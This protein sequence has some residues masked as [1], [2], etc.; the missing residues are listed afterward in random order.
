MTKVTLKAFLYPPVATWTG[1]IS[2]PAGADSTWNAVTAF[3]TSWAKYLAPHGCTGY[4][5]G[6][7]W[8]D[9]VAK[10]N[11]MCPDKESKNDTIEIMEPVLRETNDAGKGRATMKGV[12][13]F[14]AVPKISTKALGPA[15]LIAADG[16]D[17]STAGGRDFPG[18]GMNKIIASWLY[19]H[20]E[21]THPD[22]K[23]ALMDSSDNDSLLYQDFTGGPACHNPPFMRGGGSA[24]G[25]GWRKAL[26]R[27]SAELQWSGD[28]EAKL[29]RRKKAAL[30][31]TRALAKLNPDM[32]TYVNEADPDMEDVQ[33]AFWGSNYPRLLQIKKRID[34][35]GS[36]WCKQCVGGEQWEQ[37]SKGELCKV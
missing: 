18:N 19:G 2:G 20:T 12:A 5:I 23:Q 36:F 28:D 16:P 1:N 35:T 13:G 25:P 31:F 27:P 8:G 10:I 21:L 15:D 34:P 26:V 22:L 32:G 14:R 30:G 24:V 11:I 33:K 6:N 4:T 7:V 3:H 37:S 17:T 29:A 9:G